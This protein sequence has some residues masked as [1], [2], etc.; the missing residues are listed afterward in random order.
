MSSDEVSL[1]VAIE[2]TPDDWTPRLVFADW[3]EERGRPE[4]EGVRL[5]H[6][7]LV[8]GHDAEAE[9]RLQEL[10]AEGVTCPGPVRTGS[11]GGEYVLI[12]P[13]SFLMGDGDSGRVDVTISQ[14]FWIGRTP[15]TWTEY[16]IATD[17]SGQSPSDL[18]ATGVI[19]WDQAAACCA[20][21]TKRERADGRLEDGWEFTLPTE[22]E[23][24][25]ACRAGTRSPY[26]FGEDWSALATYAWYNGSPGAEETDQPRSVGMLRPNPWGLYDMLGN[27]LEWCRDGF[28]YDHE[29]GVDPFVEPHEGTRV[30]RGGEF[31]AADWCCECGSR[32]E[33]AADSRRDDLGFRAV[34]RRVP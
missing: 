4:A 13:G 21:L 5:L 29:G 3:L 22:A 11:V 9:R 23:W 12:P 24:E 16:V 20:L 8:E 26:F 33:Y 18:A 34:I 25:Y 30:T 14:A 17:T 15:I 10:L 6:T 31:R 28:A 2:Q 7:L 32:F 19:D 1:I 27:V